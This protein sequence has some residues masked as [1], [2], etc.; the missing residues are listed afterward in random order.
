MKTF[1][2]IKEGDCVYTISS[3][4]KQIYS[5]FVTRIDDNGDIFIE[6]S[7]VDHIHF[8]VP[9]SNNTLYCGVYSCIEAIIKHLDDGI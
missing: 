6:I 3:N 7:N 4:D 2:D 9:K 1:N 5:F 8:V